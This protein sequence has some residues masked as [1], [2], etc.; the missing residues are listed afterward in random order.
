[1]LPKWVMPMHQFLPHS[2]YYI[3]QCLRHMEMQNMRMCCLPCTGNHFARTPHCLR[4]GTHHRKYTHVMQ[5]VFRR[6]FPTTQPVLYQPM[7]A[8]HGDAKYESCLTFVSKAAMD[9]NI[10]EKYGLK[11]SASQN[12]HDCRRFLIHLC[13]RTNAIVY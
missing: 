7:F 9:Q 5:Y 3:S 11:K 13:Q 12:I 1:M 10:K 8:A 6:N 2:Q 4:I